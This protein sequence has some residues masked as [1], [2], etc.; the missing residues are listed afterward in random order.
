MSD[1]KPIEKLNYTFYKWIHT[2]QELENFIYVGSTANIVSRKAKHKSECN[3]VNSK[4]YNLELYKK[5]REYGYE[6]FKMVILGTAENITKREA[7]ALEEQYRIK[8]Q[9]NLNGR[10]CYRTDEEKKQADKIYYEEN[11]AEILEKTKA[12]NE[13]HKEEIKAY[14]EA[15]KEKVAEQRKIYLANNKEKVAEQR[16]IYLAN[17][18]EKIKEQK[19]N[20]YENKK[21]IN[22]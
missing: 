2:T 10:R 9:A 4:L 18:K 8:E 16:K 11:K 17:N 12:Y 20:Y 22:Y 7:E 5:M 21:H 6:N 15:N 1:Y 13:T 14:N 3:N 19:K